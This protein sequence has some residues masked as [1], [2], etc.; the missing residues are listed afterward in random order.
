[1]KILAVDDDVI[2]R[3]KLEVLL[4]AYGRCDTASGGRKALE[5]FR[6]AHAAGEPYELVTMDIDMPDMSG[7]QVVG[8][9]R[10]MEEELGAARNATILMVTVMDDLKSISSSFWKGCEGYITKPV[11]PEDIL[12]ALSK[13]YIYPAE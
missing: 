1:M 9:M 12:T 7:K 5:M 3:T 10:E 8:R 4:A 6:A 2:S 11:T 13:L